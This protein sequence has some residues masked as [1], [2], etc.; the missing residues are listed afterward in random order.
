MG[1]SG[2]GGGTGSGP[3][4]PGC[5]GR[6]RWLLTSFRYP[7]RRVLNRD[8]VVLRWLSAPGRAY[9]LETSANSI[10][11][12]WDVIATGVKGDGNMQEIIDQNPSSVSKYYRVRVK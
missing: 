2:S 4:I 11:G 6:G 1:G 9:V 5:G 3:G 8:Q 12:P 7:L 10:M